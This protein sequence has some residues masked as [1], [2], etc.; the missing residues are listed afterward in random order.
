MA[1]PAGG[2]QQ[3]R[4]YQDRYNRDRIGNSRN[5][6][7]Q[8]VV[9]RI[10]LGPQC[11][12][13]Q[14]NRAVGKIQPL[15]DQCGTGRHKLGHSVG[16]QHPAADDRHQNDGHRK[17]QE[18]EPVKGRRVAKLQKAGVGRGI[19]DEDKN[20][21]AERHQGD[22]FGRTAAGVGNHQRRSGNH[23]GHQH[24]ANGCTCDLCDH[25]LDPFLIGACGSSPRA[26]PA[27]GPPIK[28]ACPIF[29]TFL[30]KFPIHIKLESVVIPTAGVSSGKAARPSL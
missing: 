25:C 13:K 17:R 24:R 11:Q 10:C 15:T 20:A 5:R 29:D 12:G 1:G 16:Q 9:G 2:R 27:E 3:N 18:P 7:D 28:A 26:C 21:E 8:H 4:E 6:Q 23:Q 14:P 19:F 30:P 22:N